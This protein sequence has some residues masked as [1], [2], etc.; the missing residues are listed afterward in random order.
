VN[1]WANKTMRVV[2][3]MPPATQIA[4]LYFGGSNVAADAIPPTCSAWPDGN[5]SVAFPEK[6]TP[7]R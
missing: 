2:T 5:A 4:F 7:R 3:S 6:G 1:Q